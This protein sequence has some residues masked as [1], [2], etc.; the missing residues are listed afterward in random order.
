MGDML[1]E[2]R[3]TLDQAE[4]AFGAGDAKAGLQGANEVLAAF[5]AL[6]PTDADEGV[7]LRRD[8]RRLRAAALESVGELRQ[9]ITVLEQL[10]ADPTPDAAWLKGLIALSRCRRDAGDLAGAIRVLDDAAPSI[11]ALEVEDLTEAIQLIVTIAGTYI[12]V[13]ELARAA[14]MCKRALALADR[15]GSEIGR[16]SALWNLGIV[17]SYHGRVEESLAMIRQALS[18]F[19]A[20]ED[21]R[22]LPRIR[23][24]IAYCLLRLDPPEPQEAIEVLD[25]TDREMEWLGASAVD[26]ALNALTRAHAHILLGDFDGAAAAI[27]DCNKLMPR[28]AEGMTHWIRSR[29][30][31]LAAGEG[32]IDAAEGLYRRAIEKA[33]ELGDH[34]AAAQLWLELGNLLEQVGEADA[35][36]DAFRRAA[37]TAGAQARR[38]RK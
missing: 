28:D 25:Q 12:F 24:M 21:T 16:A 3:V 36:K 34:R 13:G 18:A 8:A 30:G 9:A 15:T 22:N 19:E 4:L 11:A 38:T 29:E 14:Q 1:T 2:L 5:D 17:E 31:M 35:A 10:A 37:A 6:P 32:R 7:D 27:H 20:G 26:R 23:S 33:T